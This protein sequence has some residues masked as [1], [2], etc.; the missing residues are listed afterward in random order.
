MNHRPRRE[1]TQPN[2][3]KLNLIEEKALL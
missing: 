3:C 1:R 2:R